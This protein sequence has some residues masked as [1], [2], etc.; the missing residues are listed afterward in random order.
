MV[1]DAVRFAY[2]Y[3]EAECSAGVRTDL[4]RL[5]NSGDSDQ[6][7]GINNQRCEHETG[8]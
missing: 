8:Q 7:K 3:Q 6:Y 2:C 1:P 5:K 4:D